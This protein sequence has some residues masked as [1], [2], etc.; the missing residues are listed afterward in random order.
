MADKKDDAQGSTG[1]AS[2]PPFGFAQDI[3]KQMSTAEGLSR[4]VAPP[5]PAVARDALGD[6]RGVRP[7]CEST[8]R[9]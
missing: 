4:A 1:K 2:L 3:L 5:P 7:A 8:S 9:A 6:G